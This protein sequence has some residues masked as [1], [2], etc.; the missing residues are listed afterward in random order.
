MLFIQSP[1]YQRAMIAYLRKG[2]PIALSLKMS[3]QLSEQTHP[4]THYI[5]RTSGDAKVRASHAANNGRIFAWDNR[6]IT[7]HPGEDFGCRC[8]AEPYYSDVE[9]SILESVRSYLINQLRAI[10]VWGDAEMSLYYFLSNGEKITLR[11]MGHLDAI[12]QYYNQHY[13][14]RFQLQLQERAATFSVGVFQDSFDASYNFQ[15]ILYSYRNSG[16]RGSFEGRIIQTP[17]GK[18]KLSGKT[19]FVFYDQFKDPISIAQLLTNIRN[20]APLLEPIKE[21]DLAEWLKET[22]NLWQK[23]YPITDTWEGD[24]EAIIP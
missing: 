23:P 9:P 20:A 4:T 2:T 12:K 8:K 18:R 21:K 11:E 17:D 10:S 24:Y 15:D 1:A 16:I 22:A 6:P 13:F 5:W 7:G 3:E 19:S 14:P